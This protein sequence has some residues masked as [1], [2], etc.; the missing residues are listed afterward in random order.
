[1][2]WCPVTLFNFGFVPCSAWFFD[3]ARGVVL[4]RFS[5]QRLLE[6]F[7]YGTIK[8]GMLYIFG[9]MWNRRLCH[10]YL[11]VVVLDHVEIFFSHLD[12][13]NLIIKLLDQRCCW[14]LFCYSYQ[15]YLHSIYLCHWA[16]A[17]IYIIWVGSLWA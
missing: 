13:A 10:G 11:E 4:Y 17:E 6:G 12:G 3:Q 5:N 15:A 14:M 7:L 8:T 16:F 9:Y 2:L 1:M